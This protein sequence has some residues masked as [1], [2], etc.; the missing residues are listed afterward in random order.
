[1]KNRIALTILLLAATVALAG[2]GFFAQPGMTAQEAH[3][4]HLR[5]LRVNNQQ[6]MRDIDRVLG[7]DQPS[8]LTDK[9]L[10]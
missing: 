4:E 6:M 5:I 1:M 10:Q 3:R 2:C 9:K 7:L 8:M